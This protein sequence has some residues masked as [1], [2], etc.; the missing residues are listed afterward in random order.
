MF[1]PLTRGAGHDGE[2][3]RSGSGRSGR[4]R[5]RRS[6]CVDRGLAERAARGRRSEQRQPDVLVLGRGR[7]TRRQRLAQEAGRPLRE[8][9]PQGQDHGRHAIDRHADVGLHDRGADEE[10]ARHRDAVGD[11]PRVDARMERVLG[12][13]LRLRAR[14]RDQ[15]LDRHGREHVWRQALGDAAVPARHPLRLEQGDVQEGGARS[16]QGAED[17]GAVPRRR[18]EA[19]GG[20]DHARSGWA[21][22][23]DTAAPGSSR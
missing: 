2:D 12:R 14:S 22:K 6:V 16:E 23:M 1:H 7:R 8:G 15:E 13:H 19:Q 9:A 20:G 4:R 5:G 10:R 18:Q 3:S 17:L 21:T 11:A